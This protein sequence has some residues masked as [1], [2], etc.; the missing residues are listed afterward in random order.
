MMYIW[1]QCRNVKNA[2]HSF[3]HFV[4]RNVLMANVIF[5]LH[6]LSWISKFLVVMWLS[7]HTCTYVHFQNFLVV[8]WLSLRTYVHSVIIFW[9]LTRLGICL[10]VLCD[11]IMH[12]GQELIKVPCF[13]KL[14]ADQVL[15]FWLDHGLKPGY[16]S[17]GEGRST[18]KDNIWCNLNPEALFTFVSTYSLL[19]H[20]LESP[21]YIAF[22][23]SATNVGTLKVWFLKWNNHHMLAI[24]H[25]LSFWSRGKILFIFYG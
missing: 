7:L 8:M 14:T 4:Q 5:V 10:P 18:C 1:I 22:I 24:D 6:I 12:S 11:H 9:Q 25:L 2:I 13:F 19:S 15:A 20:L 23:I 16:Y 21:W 17:G 3:F